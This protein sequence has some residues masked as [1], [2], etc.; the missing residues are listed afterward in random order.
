MVVTEE[1]SPLFCLFVWFW[2]DFLEKIPKLPRNLWSIVLCNSINQAHMQTDKSLVHRGK[3]DNLSSLH[4]R[5]MFNNQLHFKE[6]V[7]STKLKIVNHC[8]YHVIYE[9]CTISKSFSCFGFLASNFQSD[10][11]LMRIVM[12]HV[13]MIHYA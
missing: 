7:K 9:A 3:S 10:A 12:N 6:A 5:C 4:L 13:D 2:L 1:W 11:E 8:F